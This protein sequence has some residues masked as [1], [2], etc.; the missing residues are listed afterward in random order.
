MHLRNSV[1]ATALLASHVYAQSSTADASGRPIVSVLAI[2]AAG[3]QA[4]LLA[5]VV[6]NDATATTLLIGCD[7]APGDDST[8]LP[9]LC[10]L[11]SGFTVIQG[12]STFAAGYSYGVES[13]T[14][15]CELTGSPTA[16][17][18]ACKQTVVASLDDLGVGDGLTTD[19][20][21]TATGDASGSGTGLTTEVTT[22]TFAGSDITY[23]PVTITAGT[24]KSGGGGS[25]SA[26]ETGSSSASESASGTGSGSSASATG[27]GSSTTSA[28]AS[29]SG[30]SSGSGSAIVLVQ[31][32]G[33][34]LAGFVA[35]A[36]IV[37]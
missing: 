16:T 27:G 18:G 10:N 20:G 28:A 12:A 21:L 29:G 14:V 7:P 24:L 26:S 11:F 37:L 3:D 31:V 19:E 30:G 23:Y 36:M 6:D 35:V 34:A 4:N 22:T 15:G 9:D 5:S 2:G 33:L 8:E 1:A 32:S 13:M 17:T 25:E